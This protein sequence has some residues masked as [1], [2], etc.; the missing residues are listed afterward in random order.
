[1]NVDIRAGLY[2]VLIALFIAGALVS[3]WLW[4]LAGLWAALTVAL[5]VRFGMRA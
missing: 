5:V 1:M 4:V 2:G 3:P